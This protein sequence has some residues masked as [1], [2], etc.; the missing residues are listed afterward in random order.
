MGR[1]PGISLNRWG[2]GRR[3][4]SYSCAGNGDPDSG[5]DGLNDDGGRGAAAL[6][7]IRDE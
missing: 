2:E 7:L 5:W 1:L 4:C 6:V 3:V